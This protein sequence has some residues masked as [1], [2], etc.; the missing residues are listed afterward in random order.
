MRQEDYSIS[1]QTFNYCDFSSWTSWLIRQEFLWKIEVFEV[2]VEPTALNCLDYTSY[3]NYI[4]TFHTPKVHALHLSSQIYHLTK[5]ISIE[6]Q[7]PSV[8]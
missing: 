1:S 2:I 8:K 7:L 6:T 3:Q 4:L 5:N